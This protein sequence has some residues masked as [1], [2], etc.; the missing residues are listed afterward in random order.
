MQSCDAA[1][2]NARCRSK[3]ETDKDVFFLCMLFTFADQVIE[4]IETIWGEYR[5]LIR[6]QNHVRRRFSATVKLTRTF[7]GVKQPALSPSSGLW[8]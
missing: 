5:G 7:A 1:H 4:G 3:K 6:H 2:W 8:H